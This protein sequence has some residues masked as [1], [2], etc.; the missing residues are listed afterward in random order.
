MAVVKGFFT[1]PTVCIGCKACEVACKEWNQ[2]PEDGLSWSGFSYDHTQS[3]GHA[4]WRHVLFVE[5]DRALGPQQTPQTVAQS[6]GGKSQEGGGEDSAGAACG[7]H[8]GGSSND[9]PFRWIF[10]SDVCK[11]CE[12]AG[13]LEACPTGSIV[14]TEMGSV[15]VQ[16][17]VCNGC[18]Y[19]VVACP[20]GVVD[21]RPHD[22]RA[23]KCTFCYDRQKS[24][25]APA[26]ATVC[27]TQSIRFG[28]LD[29]LHDYARH[30][31]STLHA[32]GFTDAQLYTG[33][34]LPAAPSHESPA[35]QAP[36]PELLVP[37]TP[38]PELPAAKLPTLERQ[39][40]GPGTPKRSMQGLATTFP[41]GDTPA[42]TKSL[43]APRGENSGASRNSQE[44]VDE[45]GSVGHLRAFFLTL[46]PP[47]AYNLPP[48]P[49]VPTV[50]LAASWKAAGLTSLGMV[51]AG[52]F[53]ARRKREHTR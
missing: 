25:L 37:S 6:Q 1:D 50:Y 20:F 22:G 42:S 10:L 26:C 9:D 53:A 16:E 24:N 23:F 11:H 45:P 13:C 14:R 52:I 49:K 18:G 5:Q 40:P 31:L 34:P 21:R 36:T 30:R 47:Q 48:K 7:S 19:C 51:L 8:S 28:P 38:T 27:P 33:A 46:G 2:V 4:S 43:G 35:P 41:S 32:R 29:E 39:A 15:L 12:H 44:A 3:L 17:D